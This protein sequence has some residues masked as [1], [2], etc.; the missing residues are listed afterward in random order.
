[1]GLCKAV[2]LGRGVMEQ[3]GAGVVGGG[4]G[5]RPGPQDLQRPRPPAPPGTLGRCGTVGPIRPPVLAGKAQ[6]PPAGQ[7]LLPLWVF[8]ASRQSLAQTRKL[9]LKVI[10]DA[11]KRKE[12]YLFFQIPPSFCSPCIPLISTF[13]CFIGL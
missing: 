7:I 4:L 10:S 5:P 9:V 1:M 2:K 3:G 11:E 8:F 12:K 13:L 6:D